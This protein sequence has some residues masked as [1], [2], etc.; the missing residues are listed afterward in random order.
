[1]RNQKHISS[2]RNRGLTLI[3]VL[4]TLVVIS[5]GLL[6]VAALQMRTLRHNY[7]ALMRSHAS[8][9]ADDIADRMRVNRVAVRP[10][11]GSSEY[12]AEFGD[13][14]ELPN[15]ASQ[16]LRDVV[17]WKEAVAAR[18]PSGD[19]EVVVTENTGLVTIR[20]RWGERSDDPDDEA[21]TFTTETVI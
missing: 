9:L 2:R 21:I 13:P 19:G 14:P 17:E 1:M 3:E 4:V 8:A 10:A 20:V 7:D 6:G 5:M 11:S 15:D 18:L 16:A 12:D